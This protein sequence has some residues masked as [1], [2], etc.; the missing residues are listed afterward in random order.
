MKLGSF[1]SCSCWSMNHGHLRTPTAEHI[2]LNNTGLFSV[3]LEIGNVDI[4]APNVSS[5]HTFDN[6]KSET[7]YEVFVAAKDRSGN[8]GPI[9]ILEASTPDVRPPQFTGIHFP[10]HTTNHDLRICELTLFFHSM[11]CS[12]KDL[13][14][15]HSIP[16]CKE[17]SKI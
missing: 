9:A 3:A 14:F 10:C 13:K 15:S 2:F 7:A 6:L 5:T 1:V 16:H 12:A 11:V 8:H 17:K 4:S